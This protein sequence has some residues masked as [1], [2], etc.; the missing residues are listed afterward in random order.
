MYAK[1][2]RNGEPE[3]ELSPEENEAMR[4]ALQPQPAATGGD[5]QDAAAG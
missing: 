1:Q 5:R 4:L 2:I 3:L